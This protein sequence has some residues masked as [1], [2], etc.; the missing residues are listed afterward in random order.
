MILLNQKN[1]ASIDGLTNRM[2]GISPSNSREKSVFDQWLDTIAELACRNVT[3]LM[4][5]ILCYLVT[6]AGQI[7][8]AWM[9]CRWITVQ[10]LDDRQ[11]LVTRY[12]YQFF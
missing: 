10:Y 7:V 1:N 6:A 8:L 9:R 3:T 5:S 11:N 2:K 12:F 4:G